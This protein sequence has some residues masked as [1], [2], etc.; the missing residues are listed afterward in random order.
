MIGCQR[1]RR[2]WF[3]REVAVIAANTPANLVAKA[4]TSTLSIVF[5]TDTDPVQLGLV[6]SLNR[7][8]G[9]IT[10]VTLLSDEVAPK[11]VEFAH[12]LFPSASAIGFVVNPNRP[13]AETVTA[14]SR[15][16]AETLGLQFTVLHAR[17]EAELDAAVTTFSPYEVACRNRSDAFFNSRIEL[18]AA[19]ALRHLVPTIY[20]YHPF[21]AAGGLATTEAAS[22][23]STASPVSMPAAYSRARNRRTCQVQESPRPS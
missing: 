23:I 10:A 16:A 20:E 6:A 22:Q 18:L 13:T 8:G 11:R 3:I 17:T 12:K 4:A 1:W 14:A 19:L 7:P 2:I 15:A 21:V 5:T 9:N